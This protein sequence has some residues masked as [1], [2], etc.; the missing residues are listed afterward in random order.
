M[1]TLLLPVTHVSSLKDCSSLRAGVSRH[2][3]MV[4]I[5]DK[6]SSP[7]TKKL[8]AKNVWDHLSTMYDLQAL[9]RLIMIMNTVRVLLY[10]S[11][12]RHTKT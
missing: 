10:V 8:T 7:A 3:H 12:V 5:H 9:V 4:V 2:F 1:L 6:L 11:N